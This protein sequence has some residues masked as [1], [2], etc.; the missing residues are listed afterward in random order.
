MTMRNGDR[1]S[2]ELR[3]PADL[4]ALMGVPFSE[5]QLAAITAPLEPGVIVAGA[6]SGK[7]TVMAARVVWLV[8]TGAVAADEILGLT[9]T[10]KAAAELGQRVRKALGETGLLRRVVPSADAP[11]ELAEPEIAE[12][13]VLTYHAYAAR[14]LTE[15]GLRIGHEPDTAVI[16]DASRFQL[17]AR[18]LRDHTQPIDHL[19][20]WLPTN[21]T[22]LLQLDAQLAEHLV[23]T[24]DVR[25][26]Q[27]AEIDEWREVAKPVEA[28]R[29]LVMAMQKRAELLALVDDYQALK[30]RLGV[31]DFSDQMALGAQL[32]EQRREVGR[33]EREKYKVVLLDEYQDTS[34]AQARLLTALFSGPIDDGRGYPVTAVGDPCQAIYGW[35]GASVSN[36]EQFGHDFP[37][38][39][40]GA[41]VVRFPLSVNRR[42]DA[43]ILAAANQ[44]AGPLY[45]DH[46]AS[47]P[48]EP[49]GAATA[50]VVRAASLTTY[51]EELEFLATEV[52]RAHTAMPVPLWSNIGILVRDNKTANDVHDALTTVGVPVEVV[53]LN[54]LL[55]MPEVAAVVAT[56]QVIHDVTANSA[57]LTLLTAPRWAIGPRDLALLGRRARQLARGPETAVDDIAGKLE[58]AVAGVDPADIVSLVEALDDPG[59]APYS[60]QA[61]HRFRQLS[62]ELRTLR[63]HV[64]EPLL[65]LVRRVIDVTGLDVELASSTSPVA[66]ARRDNVS[67]F[68]DA[69]SAFAGIDGDASLPGLLA[70]LAAEEEYGQGLSLAVPSEANSV[71]LLTVH[72][73]KGLEWDIVFVPGVCHKVFP[74]GQ[75][76]SRWTSAPAELPWPLRGDYVDL[77]KVSDVSGKGITAFVEECKAYELQE[78]RRLAYVAVTRP[79][80]QLVVSCHW[81]GPEQKVRRGPS[82]FFDEIVAAMQSWGAAPELVAP[83]PDDDTVNPANRADERFS[84]PVE[85]GDDEVARREA[86]AALVAAATAHGIAASTAEADN[87][88]MLDEIGRVQQWDVELERLVAEA[89]A[90]R[91]DEIVV[92]LPPALSATTVLRLQ[93]DPQSL[94]RDLARPMP[95]RPSASARFGTR[96]HAWVEQHVGRQQELLEPDDLPGRGDVDIE[97]DD[98]LRELVEAFAAGPFGTRIP[99]QIEAP[100]ALVL[101]SQ[102][103]RGRIDAVYETPTGFLVVDWKTNRKQDAD[104]LQLAIYRLAWSELMQVPLARVETAFYYVRSGDVVE[105][106]DLPDRAALERLVTSPGSGG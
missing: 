67:T 19:N 40:A 49:A 20:T 4:A 35:R 65:D 39:G 44:L 60:E 69:V 27:A 72:R 84:W 90:G 97:G 95:R 85:A 88:L 43:R 2:D 80:R 7:T 77:P 46:A 5:Q 9:F 14:L 87:Q 89:R 91:A 38:A 1:A 24:D 73:A 42:S 92:T 102:V 61:R 64:G 16:A 29:K 98:E 54:G 13:T 30:R 63:R 32:A 71:K 8:G 79:R 78:E 34:V 105:H 22:A 17:A 25:R 59:G 31:M 51:A 101:A 100:F 68:L 96:F 15:H 33:A 81:W 103:V 58:E 99:Y 26:F 55:R 75:G 106:V 62:R 76:R 66:A 56:L 12:P 28:T 18:V 86:A 104:P 48:L 57:L 74:S 41:E 94:A 21:V 82:L 47:L 70:Y 6:G 11:D 23:S 53:G 50:G 45:A 3:T 37:L 52:P 93:D 10:N 83:V 36:I